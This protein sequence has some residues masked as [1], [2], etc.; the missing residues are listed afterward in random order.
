MYSNESPK[1]FQTAKKMLDAVWETLASTFS[2]TLDLAEN[3][4]TCLYIFEAYQN[5][6]RASVKCKHKLA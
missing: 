6:G 2:L 3:D 5:A 1:Q 4:D